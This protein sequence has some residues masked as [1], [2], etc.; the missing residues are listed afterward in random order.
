MDSG[1]AQGRA[2]SLDAP[3]LVRTP[4]GLPLCVV[5]HHP[6]GCCE[7][8][9]LGNTALGGRSSSSEVVHACRIPPPPALTRSATARQGLPLPHRLG[10][11]PAVRCSTHPPRARLPQDA[12]SCELN[13]AAVELGA[14][15]PPALPPAPAPSD[16]AVGGPWHVPTDESSD[17][18]GGRYALRDRGGRGEGAAPR[19]S[20]SRAAT[21]V[22]APPPEGA[23]ASLGSSESVAAAH[24]ESSVRKRPSRVA[25]ARSSDLP[26]PSAAPKRARSEAAEGPR[27]RPRHAREAAAEQTL[28]LHL[29]A[30]PGALAGA[31]PA[32]PRVSGAEELFVF[33]DQCD[34]PQRAVLHCCCASC[35]DASSF[36]PQRQPSQWS[37]CFAA[38]V[39]GQCG[40]C[41]QSGAV[42][43][44]QSQWV[45]LLAS[46]L[47]RRLGHVL[48]W[49]TGAGCATLLALRQGTHGAW[50]AWCASFQH[51]CTGGR[52]VAAAQQQCPTAPVHR[53]RSRALARALSPAR[54]RASQAVGRQSR[55]WSR[56]RVS[57]RKRFAARVRS[58]LL[59]TC[60]RAPAGPEQD[61]AAP[62]VQCLECFT[63]YATASV[64]VRAT[65]CAAGVPRTTE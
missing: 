5:C 26:V 53:L 28:A 15:P 62:H 50:G 31:E 1:G 18:G 10:R 42:Q 55:L 27:R 20:L 4:S 47:V 45:S 16:A 24:C 3:L 21:V 54:P 6:A 32:T 13:P 17:A 49:W 61:V 57:P 43:R 9:D 22:L 25:S 52:S 30:A 64:S 58:G 40:R 11:P 48:R 65:P 56:S 19:R 34:G 41:E 7:H 29:A 33:C 39:A 2:P 36:V 46:H 38:R 44:G 37:D 59:I 14:A 60:C 12:V 51:A 8:T 63:N 35:R 23:A